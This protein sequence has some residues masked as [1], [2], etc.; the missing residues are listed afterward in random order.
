MPQEDES[1]ESAPT[2]DFDTPW[3]EVLEAYFEDFISFFFPEAYQGINWQ[4]SHN[5]LDKE[6]QQVAK[7]AEL[8]RRYADK[9]VQVHRKDGEEVWVL[10]HIEI[11]SQHDRD[12]TKRMFTYNYRIFDFYD[13]PVVSMAVLADNNSSWRPTGF[14]WKLWGCRV[15]IEFPT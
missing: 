14:S 9:L 13:R 3:K 10:I 5:F 15:G 4:V 2:N 1:N 11:Q 12:F 6:L 8:G 7:D